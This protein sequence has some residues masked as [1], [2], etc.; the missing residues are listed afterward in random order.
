MRRSPRLLITTRGAVTHDRC[1]HL[2]VCGEGAAG[3]GSLIGAWIDEAKRALSLQP[4]QCSSNIHSSHFSI[5]PGVVTCSVL[6]SVA[7]SPLGAVRNL[8]TP[9]TVP[10]PA[11]HGGDTALNGLCHVIQPAAVNYLAIDP[12]LFHGRQSIPRRCPDSANAQSCRVHAARAT[13][14]K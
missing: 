9:A 4:S 12:G 3:G 8:R 7:L 14:T 2:Q 11:R 6:F 5:D 10:P 13:A 1:L